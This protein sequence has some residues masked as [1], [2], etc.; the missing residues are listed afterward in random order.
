MTYSRRT[1]APICLLG[2]VAFACTYSAFAEPPVRFQ[3]RQLDSRFRSEGVAVA[4]FNRDGKND[5]AAGSHYYA[6]PDWKIVR[7]AEE[8]K[9]YKP[10]GYAR[11][12]NNFADDFNKDGWPDLLVVEW[13]GSIAAWW[14][15]PQQEGAPWNKH[16]LAPVASNESPQ[17]VDVD[18]DGTREFICGVS[19]VV[20]QPDSPR[21]YLAL[22]YAGEDPTKPWQSAHISGFG[23]PGS[24]RYSHG[25]GSGD[26][27]GD[28][29][30]DVLVKEGWFE[31]PDDRRKGDWKFHPVNL[32]EDCADMHVADFD[33]DGDA[34]VLSSSAHR[35]GIWWHEQLPGGKF[36]T[37]TI[38]DDVSQT[39]SLQTADID[40][41]GLLDF[42]TGKRYH[43]HNGRDPGAAETPYLMWFRL[44]RREGQPEWVRYVIDD[45]SGV[46]TQF[47][48]ADV[49]GDGRPDV[50]TS[51]KKGV[52]MF[53]QTP[54]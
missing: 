26:I 41:D 38:A 11:S 31:A 30:A 37:H 19:P 52:H 15:N 40:G 42:V 47:V 10:N 54:K 18:G 7:V 53:V 35:Y 17:F 3:K 36:K 8:P 33:G 43:A 34:D 48:V 44:T 39:H 22:H 50:V 24:K 12:F 6:A 51:N 29:R 9:E 28:G 25:L 27:N 13:P 2:F 49:N 14:E 1:T 32:G 4:D 46:G 21:R 45:D 5:V 16:T 20:N 23:G